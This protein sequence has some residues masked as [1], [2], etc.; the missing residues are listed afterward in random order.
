MKRIEF[1]THFMGFAGLGWLLPAVLE[2]P[3]DYDSDKPAMSFKDIAG[4]SQGKDYTLYEGWTAGHTYYNGPAI[5]EKLRA[6]HSLQLR[7]E[8]GNKYDEKAIE[9]YTD[10]YK[11]GY[12]AQADN[13]V[14]A[15]LMDQG[16][17]LKAEIAE[18]NRDDPIWFRERIKL[19]V[20]M[21]PLG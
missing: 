14:L 5:L 10:R 6:G 12:I 11:L 3:G 20:W 4:L 18:I 15:N 1:I 17:P 2:K 7:R 8:T 13:H 19:R 16:I 9:I 21:G